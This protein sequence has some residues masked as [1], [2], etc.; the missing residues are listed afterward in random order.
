M[1]KISMFLWIES[2]KTFNISKTFKV[3]HNFNVN[4][5]FIG[6]LTTHVYTI[7]SYIT[8]IAQTHKMYRTPFYN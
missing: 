7:V 8:P 1:R 4:H 5:N 6:L 2:M 3:N